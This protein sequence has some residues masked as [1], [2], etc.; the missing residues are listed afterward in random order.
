MCPKP[1]QQAIKEAWQGDQTSLGELVKYGECC[2]VLHHISP[3]S[4][5][6]VREGVKMTHG[7]SRSF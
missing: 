1:L 5:V 6:L 3:K 2:F 7:L 4:V